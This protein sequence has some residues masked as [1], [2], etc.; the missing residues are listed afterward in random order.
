ML[1]TPIGALEAVAINAPLKRNGIF[2]LFFN[3]RLFKIKIRIG[4][5]IKILPSLLKNSVIKKQSIK[6]F[7]YNRIPEPF[8]IFNINA[9]VQLKKPKLSSTMAITIVAMM[10]IAA[11][12]TFELISNKSPVET[13][14]LTKTIMAPIAAG[15]ASFIFFGRIKIRTIVRIKAKMVM[16]TVD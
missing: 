5:V 10:V 13:L 9:A 12:V 1:L 16:I 4:V 15:I 3:F 2:C 8:D 11:P 7:Q 6:V 14:P